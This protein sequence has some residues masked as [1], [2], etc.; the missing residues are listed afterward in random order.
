MTMVS[1]ARNH[2][3]VVL[4]RALSAQGPGFYIDVGAGHPVEDS[5]TK[6]FYD[7]G[8]SGVNVEPAAKMFE[9]LVGQ[10]ARDVNL[11]LRLSDDSD[12][13]ESLTTL[14]EV[15]RRYAPPMF[16]FLVVRTAA[17]EGAV[18]KGGD[19]GGWKPRIV[20]VQSV[21][22]EGWEHI[23]LGAGY[24]SAAFDGVNRI[25]VQ[26][27]DAESRCALATPA[28]VTDDFIPYRY[29]RLIDDMR[30]RL[31]DARRVMAMT[32]TGLADAQALYLQLLDEVVDVRA[33]CDDVRG[34]LEG[35]D[36]LGM[37][38]ARRVT[39]LSARLPGAF[40]GAHRV[41]DFRLALK[42][43]KGWEPE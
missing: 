6:H 14:A 42:K 5:V 8:W 26:A 23:L 35:I 10:R 38:L 18:L 37:G 15:C 2:E 3:D 1:Y 28:N 43:A 19:W 32:R 24:V 34:Q 16:G 36:P 39:R 12:A 29:S 9:A 25:Y 27:E 7:M 41:A 22:C 20:V 30:E 17:N 40:A 31:E 4:N 11:R 33:Q 21:F 13:E